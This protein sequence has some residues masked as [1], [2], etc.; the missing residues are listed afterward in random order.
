MKKKS[1][2][3]LDKVVQAY[4]LRIF[5]Q[6]SL[7]KFFKLFGEVPSKLRRI[8]FR[9]QKQNPHWVEVGVRR[10]PLGQLYGCDAQRPHVSFSI[11]SCNNMGLKN[12]NL[13]FCFWHL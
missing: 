9:N 10:F 2:L 13:Y 5:V 4:I 3:T 7:N 8:I 1:S 11:V 6:T 12:V